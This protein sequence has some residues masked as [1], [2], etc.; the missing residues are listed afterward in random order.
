MSEESADKTVGSLGE[1]RK[2]RVL[3]SLG[4]ARTDRET[5]KDVFSLLR[6]T[7]GLLWSLRV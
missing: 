3:E 5:C 2:E 4:Q 6:R 7:I 1:E